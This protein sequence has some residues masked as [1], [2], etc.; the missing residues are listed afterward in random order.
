MV[1]HL[2][3]II[4]PSPEVVI[5]DLSRPGAALAAPRRA[6]DEAQVMGVPALIASLTDAF[7]EIIAYGIGA[8]LGVSPIENLSA[9]VQVREWARGEFIR[10]QTIIEGKNRFEASRRHYIPGTAVRCCS[11]RG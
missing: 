6:R 10:A 3:V 9:V 5:A 4:H 11:S 7:D 8:A 2:P 1:A